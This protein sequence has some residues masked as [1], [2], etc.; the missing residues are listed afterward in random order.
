MDNNFKL[1]LAT[2]APGSMWSM[3]SHRFKRSI[4][5]FDFTDEN[6]QRFYDL[7]KTHT[8]VNYIINEDN[9][10]AKGHRGSYFGPYHEFGQQFDDLRYYQNVEN[11]YNECL[12]PFNNDQRPYKLIKS[13]W[14]SYNLDWLW[15]NCKGHK[16]MLIWREPQ[17][18]ENWWYSMGGWD[19]RYPVYTWYNNPA[20]MKEK[21]KEESDLIQ[22]FAEKHNITWVDFD[23]SGDWVYKNF[24]EAQI[25]DPKANPVIDDIIKVAYF[26]IV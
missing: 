11:F 1:I 15:E 18:A 9:W 24:P 22:G 20:R 6:E 10:K 12:K 25:I 16:M 23:I 26:D 14:F 2:G 13:H 3:I 5:K 4:N 21:I 17:A 7:P 8:N 19:I